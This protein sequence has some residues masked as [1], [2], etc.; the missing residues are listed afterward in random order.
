MGD[1]IAFTGS[2]TGYVEMKVKEMYNDSGKIKK[3]AKGEII[4]VKTTE[5]VRENDKVYLI[6]K[7]DLRRDLIIER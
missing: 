3:A 4:T 5:L 7:R 1:K 6:R 2:T